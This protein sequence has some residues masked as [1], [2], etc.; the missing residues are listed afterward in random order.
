M[1]CPKAVFCCWALRGVTAAQ[2]LV[3]GWS[4]QPLRTFPS[5]LW[6]LSWMLQ[7]FSS[8]PLGVCAKC[9]VL[10]LGVQIM[11]ALSS[12]D[13]Y[14]S[15]STCVSTLWSPRGTKV[16]KK[17]PPHCPSVL[18]L[19]KWAINLRVKLLSQHTWQ[20]CS[21]KWNSVKVKHLSIPEPG[22]LISQI[23]TFLTCKT[24][25]NNSLYETGGDVWPKG[26]KTRRVN[27]Y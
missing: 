15:L 22:A 25:D 12:V 13:F 1:L 20:T 26:L 18:R 19:S 23:L 10:H 17:C 11:P 14:V 3:L 2:G 9:S 24:E 7:E 8:A 16:D 6:E 4:K 21:F 27:F 5:L